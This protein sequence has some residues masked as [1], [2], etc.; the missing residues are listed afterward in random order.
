MNGCYNGQLSIRFA[1]HTQIRMAS[2]KVLELFLRKLL[3]EAQ[4]KDPI[5]RYFQR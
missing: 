4:R 5:G 3:L 1:F 2:A